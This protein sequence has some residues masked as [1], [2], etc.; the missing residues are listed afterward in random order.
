MILFDG[1]C[2]LCDAWVQFVIRR[3]PP[4]TFRF[5]ALQ[6]E[7]AAQLLERHGHANEDLSTMI[8]V[9]GGR[10]YVRSS[11]GLRVLRRLRWPW[12]LLSVFL[13]VPAFLRDPFYRLV[14]S[15]R[16]RWFG[17][18]ECLLIPAAEQASRFLPDGTPT[19]PP[20]V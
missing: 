8:L 2:N 3:D 10:V 15:R 4:G 17:K 6:S 19:P 11:A 16:Y 1:V 14:S 13:L 7:A 9:D 12:P 5:A 20:A 18:K